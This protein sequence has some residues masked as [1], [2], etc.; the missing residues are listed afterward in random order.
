MFKSFSRSRH[1]IILQVWGD[2]F[3]GETNILN[4]C[5]C[6]LRKKMDEGFSCHLINTVRGAG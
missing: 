4:V 3:E 5:I 1:N 2:E 6:S